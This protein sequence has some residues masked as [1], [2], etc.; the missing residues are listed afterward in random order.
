[1]NKEQK[2]DLAKIIITII[3]SLLISLSNISNSNLKFL[4][5]LIP[6]FIIGYDVLKKAIKGII[7]LQ[8]FDEIFL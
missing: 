4:L 3:F 2:I 1:M 8:P 6:Y 5:Y 7:N